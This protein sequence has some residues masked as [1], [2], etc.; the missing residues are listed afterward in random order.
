MGKSGK[1]QKK[2]ITLNLLVIKY[3]LSFYPYRLSM[4]KFTAP[5]LTLFFWEKVRK[6]EESQRLTLTDFLRSTAL[7]KLPI[8]IKLLESGV[9]GKYG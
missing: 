4:L 1:K 5:F 2:S 3:K 6:G 7:Q 9:K 8:L